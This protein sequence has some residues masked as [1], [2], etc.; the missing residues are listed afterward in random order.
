MESERWWVSGGTEGQRCAQWTAGRDTRPLCLG[1]RVIL[2]SRYGK[3]LIT[4]FEGQGYEKIR[5]T[6]CLC[7]FLMLLQLKIFNMASCHT[8]RY[9]ILNPICTLFDQMIKRPD[10]FGF[11]G[12]TLLDYQ[13]KSHGGDR[14]CIH[15]SSFPTRSR[16]TLLSNSCQAHS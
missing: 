13:D 12:H 5:V 15:K 6:F 14:L 1:I 7:S 4:S 2:S 11:S 9:H 16:P 10:D 8:L 3:G